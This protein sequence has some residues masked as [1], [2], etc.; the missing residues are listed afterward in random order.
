[1]K[2]WFGAIGGDNGVM[3]WTLFITFM[4]ATPVIEIG[5]TWYLGYWANQYK[6]HD[7]SEVSAP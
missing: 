7:P 5:L 2:M 1:M 3:F 6:D 4:I